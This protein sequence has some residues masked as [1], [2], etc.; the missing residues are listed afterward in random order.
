MTADKT[1]NM[2]LK[3]ERRIKVIPTELIKL[4]AF[5][6]VRS[7]GKRTITRKAAEAAE[8]KE[9]LKCFKCKNHHLDKNC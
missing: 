9:I 3:E 7:F 5:T 1:R 4:E 8:I 2:L 6:A